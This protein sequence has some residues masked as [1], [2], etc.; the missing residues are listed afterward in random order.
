MD[1]KK[2]RLLAPPTSYGKN[3][4]RLKTELE[5]QVGEV[6]YNPTGKPLK[7]AEVACL[8]PGIDG[9]IAGLDEID[10]SALSCADRLKVIA[11]YGVGVD[12]VDLVAARANRTVVTNTPGLTS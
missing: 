11:R 2:C 5:A 10:A 9:Y 4:P 6:I 1:L 7:S 3:D 8:L 12:S